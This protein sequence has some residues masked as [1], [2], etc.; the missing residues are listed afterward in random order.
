[1]TTDDTQD[2]FPTF[3]HVA[4]RLVS[5]L[6]LTDPDAAPFTI[7][8]IWAPTT[9]LYQVVDPA[10]RVLNTEGR[11]DS[12]DIHALDIAADLF[13]QPQ[14]A[15]QG[16]S[17]GFSS[18]Q[19]HQLARQHAATLVDATGRTAVDVLVARAKA[20]LTKAQKT[21]L[22]DLGNPD[23]R[24][25]TPYLYRSTRTTYRRRVA[26]QPQTN[27]PA[28][29]ALIDAGLAKVSSE[30]GDFNYT[31]VVKLTALGRAVLDAIAKNAK[32]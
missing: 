28:V 9:D 8:V 1:M 3:S 22:T 6:P 20:Q 25:T 18:E 16:C 12:H 19:A 5:L 11:W 13:S 31:R 4:T 15:G 23:V 30:E 2:S 27:V 29:A 26:G 17:H 14:P 7:R 21:A 24:I 10:G 32:K